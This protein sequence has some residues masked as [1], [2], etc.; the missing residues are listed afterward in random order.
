M[1]R[2]EDLS[3]TELELQKKLTQERRVILHK[4]ISDLNH[5]IIR[6]EQELVFRAREGT[7]DQGQSIVI[8]VGK[9]EV[10]R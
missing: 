6:I 3:Q 4:E 7:D 10:R 1:I 2:I 5:N 8:S 9:W